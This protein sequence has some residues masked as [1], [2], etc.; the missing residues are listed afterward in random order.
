MTVLVAGAPGCGPCC[1]GSGADGS[2]ACLVLFTYARKIIEGASTIIIIESASTMII[3]EGA[4]TTAQICKVK[5]LT[6]FI[7]RTGGRPADVAPSTAPIDRDRQAEPGAA[8]IHKIVV[9]K[10]IYNGPHRRPAGGRGALDGP[11]RARPPRGSRG[12]VGARR[13]REGDSRFAVGRDFAA[14]VKNGVSGFRGSGFGLLGF[15]G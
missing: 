8:R 1:C 6:S 2:T 11:N 13:P 14:A 5:F 7:F 10:E 9:L 4:S 3:I 12:G 15:Q